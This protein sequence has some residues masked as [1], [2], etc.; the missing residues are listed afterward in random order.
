MGDRIDR[1]GPSSY[2]ECLGAFRNVRL[3]HRTKRLVHSEA[4][5]FG[6]DLDSS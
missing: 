6:W 5:S 1:N 4:Y 3:S 2:W